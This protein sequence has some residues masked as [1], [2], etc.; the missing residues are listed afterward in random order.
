[1]A[2]ES[3]CPDSGGITALMCPPA[4]F[5][6]RYEIN[7]WMD[8]RRPPRKGLAHQQWEILNGTLAQ[9]MGINIELI[10]A[11][12]GLPDFVFTANAGLCM[13]NT[14]IAS[15]FR[16][17]QRSPEEAHWEQWFAARGYQVVRLPPGLHFEGEGDVL[18]C[19]HLLAAGYRFRSDREAVFHVSQLLEKELLALELVDPWFYHLDTCF[20]PLGPDTVLYYPPAFSEES[21]RRIV[22]RFSRAIPVVDEEARRLVCNLVAAD[23]QVVISANC[24]VARTQLL[25]LG[26]VVNEVEVS[27]FMKAGGGAKCL[28]LF[29]ASTPELSQASGPLAYAS[30]TA[31]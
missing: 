26:Y 8:R 20:A 2:S 23:R 28:V 27:E 25:N 19:G 9:K 31:G 5:G 22:E 1:M 17:R 29:L 30:A 16:Y 12:A 21:R 4:H 7:P 6:V 18:Q 3:T 15:R 24:P 14:S 11:V 13:G 10:D